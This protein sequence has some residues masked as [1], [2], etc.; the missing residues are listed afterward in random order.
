[1][2]NLAFVAAMIPA[3]LALLVLIGAEAAYLA[4]IMVLEVAILA[5]MGISP[6]LTSH[7]VGDG[8]LVL[9][10]GWYFRAEVPIKDIRIVARIDRGPAR[11]GVFFK[12][13]DATLYVTSRRDDLIEARLRSK[14][15]FGWALGKRADRVVFDAENA[16][17]MVQAIKDD[18]SF[19]PV[20]A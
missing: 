13:L 6:L 11:T 5:V 4:I 19:T 10:Q 2:Q 8:T 20:D 1:M 7:E 14:R 3:T 12:L 18:G 15:T 9:R 16:L 17:A